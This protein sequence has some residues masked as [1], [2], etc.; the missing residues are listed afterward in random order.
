MRNQDSL[1]EPEKHPSHCRFTDLTGQTFGRLT[2]AY[3]AGQKNSKSQ[4][5]ADCSCGTRKAVMARGLVRGAITSCGC[6]HRE[7]VGARYRTHGKSKH[8]IYAIWLALRDRCNNPRNK[9]YFRYGGR[10]I[11]V[12]ERWNNFE[13]FLADMGDRPSPKHSID[14]QDNDGNYSPENCWWVLSETQ[15][16][17][18]RNNRHLTLN[19]VTKTVMQWSRESGIHHDAIYGRLRAGAT[20]AEALTGYTL[21][22]EALA[23]GEK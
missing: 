15:G 11:Q 14:R 19:G 1:P 13:N 10:G 4:W 2:I 22:Q 20:D 12:C 16:N 5:V 3:Y 8:P 6:L 18:K 21:A 7:M 17:N 23:G 9:N